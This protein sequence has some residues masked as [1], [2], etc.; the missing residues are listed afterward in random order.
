MSKLCCGHTYQGVITSTAEPR[1][2]TLGDVAGRLGCSPMRWGSDGDKLPAPGPGAETVRITSFIHILPLRPHT[3]GE[4]VF[5]C[6]PF[7]DEATE[8]QI[9]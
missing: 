1:G 2:P 3:P 8:A 9:A 5:S 7:T 4:G 6:S